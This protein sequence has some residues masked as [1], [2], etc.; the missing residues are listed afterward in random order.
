MCYATDLH[1]GMRTHIRGERARANG[2]IALAYAHPKGEGLDTPPWSH[3]R[4]LAEARACA[5]CVIIHVSMFIET[6]LSIYL[7]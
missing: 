5:R 6:I 4:A 3:A 1:R 2:Y 7:Y